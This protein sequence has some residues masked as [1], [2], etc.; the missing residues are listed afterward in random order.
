MLRCAVP[1]KPMNRHSRFGFRRLSTSY[2]C[3]TAPDRKFLSPVRLGLISLTDGIC[4]GKF[5]WMDISISYSS[6]INSLPGAKASVLA[7]LGSSGF[8]E[9]AHPLGQRREDAR[10]S[11]TCFVVRVC[12]RGIAGM[13]QVTGAKPV[14]LPSCGCGQLAGSRRQRTSTQDRRYCPH[15]PYTKQDVNWRT[16]PKLLNREGTNGPGKWIST[17]D[18]LALH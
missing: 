2:T 16:Q 18:I 8:R 6:L 10:L 17:I 5:S 11:G 7:A 12:M 9:Q 4:L 1:S 15:C 3:S 14:C 13:E